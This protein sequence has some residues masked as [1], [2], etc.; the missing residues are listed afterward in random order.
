MHRKI[1]QLKPGVPR[2]V[3]L[4]VAGSIWCFVGIFL[5]ARGSHWLYEISKLWIV[6]PGI[7]FGTLKAL[8][9]LDR[10]AEKNIRRIVEGG[11]DRCLGGVYSWKTWLLVFLM[12]GMGFLLRNSSLPKE[13]LGL[14]Y[15]SIGWGLLFSSRKCWSAW[16]L[17]LK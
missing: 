9:M 7:A 14:F 11:N 5:M 10:S 4:F 6:L 15:V 17:S 8:F 1:Q 2:S 13:Y 16:R 12:M 3:H